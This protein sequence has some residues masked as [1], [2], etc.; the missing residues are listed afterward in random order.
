MVALIYLLLVINLKQLNF[1][2]IS[3]K[4]LKIFA[5]IFQIVGQVEIKLNKT[6]IT[7][8]KFVLILFH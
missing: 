4:Y 5:K 8:Y 3:N 7:F 1:N 2:F 6:L